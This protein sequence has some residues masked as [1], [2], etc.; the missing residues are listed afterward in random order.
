M[1]VKQLTSSGKVVTLFDRFRHALPLS[2]INEI[3]ASMAEKVL[4]Q[5]PQTF[6][7]TS[8]C[9]GHFVHFCWDNNELNEDT[10]SG[11]NTTHCT[12]GILIQWK[13]RLDQQLAKTSAVQ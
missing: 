13:V 8:I 2:Q 6:V 11:A 3:E 4:Q 5:D 9:Q 12:N 10:L 1:V 7:P